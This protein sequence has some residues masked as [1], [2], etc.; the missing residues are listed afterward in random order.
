MVSGCAEDGLG[1][2]AMNFQFILG[3]W[4]DSSTMFHINNTGWW[5]KYVVV[6]PYS[7]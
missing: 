2:F 5:V 6:Q 7:G 1:D 4:V 3:T